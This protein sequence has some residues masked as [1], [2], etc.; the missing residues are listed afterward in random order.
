MSLFDED[1]HRKCLTPAERD[2]LFKAA[3]DAD[4]EVRTFC[5]TLA[6][7]VCRISEAIN[8]T[9]DRVDLKAGVIVFE[10][11]KK[12]KRGVY[13]SIPVP[14]VL[15]DTVQN[16]LGHAQRSTT[17]IYAEATGPEAKQ[18]AEGMWTHG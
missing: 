9:A 12:Q 13:R 6:F 10:S 2:A 18:I 16:W 3:D 15:R 1:G 11:L 4:R 14:S 7:T 8:L 17:S 5:S